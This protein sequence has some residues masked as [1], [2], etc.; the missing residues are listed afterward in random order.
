VRGLR[1]GSGSLPLTSDPLFTHCWHCQRQTGTALVINLLI[2][3]DRVELL[4][5]DQQP[6]EAP[7]DDGSTQRIFRCPTCQVAVYTQYGHTGLRLVRGPTLDQP[8]ERGQALEGLLWFF[9]RRRLPPQ[10]GGTFRWQC[11]QRL[12]RCRK[13]CAVVSS[14]SPEALRGRWH[15]LASDSSRES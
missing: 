7:P 10:V 4:A 5:G 8:L 13:S 2:E 1:L 3:T 15:C 11:V 9:P 6:V 14:T 12:A